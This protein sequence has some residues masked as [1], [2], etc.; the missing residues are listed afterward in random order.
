MVRVATYDFPASND[1]LR[2]TIVL[3]GCVLYGFRLAAP[4]Q[5]LDLTTCRYSGCAPNGYLLP[6]SLLSVAMSKEGE[7]YPEQEY[8]KI[9]R[10]QPRRPNENTYWVTSRLLAGE[11]PTDKRGEEESRNKIRRYLD[12]GID[13]F[14]DLTLEGEKES[15]QRILKEESA[16]CNMR[17]RYRRFPVQD[18][19]IPTKKEMQMILDSIDAAIADNKRVYVHCRGGIGRTGT[20]VGCFLA[21]HG[22]GGEEALAEVNR[23][24]KNSNRSYESSC[25]PETKDQMRMVRE[26]DE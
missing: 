13:C 18:F 2:Q 8:I 25:S 19:G 12:L 23:L 4:F 20:T 21:R 10:N 9:L 26:W 24:F 14:V 1:H 17:A 15:Y 6:S 3:I 22:F 7:R 16:R 5:Y 11:Y